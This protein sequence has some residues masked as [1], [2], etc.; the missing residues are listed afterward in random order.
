MIQTTPLSTTSV[1]PT[2]TKRGELLRINFLL[3][4]IAL[5][6]MLIK[7]N[8]YPRPWYD[9]GYS[10]QVS[11]S[12]VHEGFYGTYNAT[13]GYRPFDPTISSGPMTILPVALAFKLFGSGYMQARTVV[14]IYGILGLLVAYG[15]MRDLFSSSVGLIAVLLMILPGLFTFESV[16]YIQLSRQMLGEVPS[17]ALIILGLWI[18]FYAWDKGGIG[19]LILGGLAMGLG[20]SSK[21]QVV[22]TFGTAIGIIA[23]IRTFWKPRW[24]LRYL[25]PPA[26]VVGV[27]VGWTLIQNAGMTAQMRQESPALLTEAMQLHFFTGLF[28]RTISNTGWL[29]SALMIFSGGMTLIMLALRSRAQEVLTNADWGAAVLALIAIVMAVWYAFLSVG[30][31]R[32]TFLGLM[33]SLLLLG[34]IVYKGLMLVSDRLHISSQLLLIAVVIVLIL[35]DVGG[36]A[37]AIVSH[38][39]D[40]NAVEEM[41]NYIDANIPPTAVIESVEVELNSLTTHH[42]FHRANYTYLYEAIR[43]RWHE[44][45][46][47]DLKYNLL[48]ANPDY[49]VIGKTSNWL[50][51][52]DTAQVQLNF[53]PVIQFGDYQLLEYKR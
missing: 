14:V 9:E 51:L 45:I 48:Q 26:L 4:L 31:E 53:R 27:F 34:N 15:L 1:P 11:Q 23:L 20:V 40:E 19:L 39:H 41:A 5:P 6:L 2:T 8:I 33:F 35:V 50:E 18:W 42:E 44:N 43:Q 38:W 10:I 52:Y 16:G 49:I 36:N 29:L 32:Y 3:L 22:F 37:Y 21:P 7:L 28:G 24:F 25:L 13:E 30:F 17:F 47:F 12:V 46:P